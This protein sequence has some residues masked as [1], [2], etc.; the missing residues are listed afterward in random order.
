M[1]EG[2]FE[3][4]GCKWAKGEGLYVK[5][6]S[7]CSVRLF[8]LSARRQGQGLSPYPFPLR[9]CPW[10]ICRHCL[11]PLRGFGGAAEWHSAEGLSRGSA[12]YYLRCFP[13]LHMPPRY[14]TVC[15]PYSLVPIFAPELLNFKG[16]SS[17]VIAARYPPL[18][19]DKE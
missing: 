4:S 8:Q 14:H 19:I 11:L 10:V 5:R 1:K 12:Q 3:S 16:N 7:S 17:K 13:T 18:H 6:D 2:S 9:A 15:G